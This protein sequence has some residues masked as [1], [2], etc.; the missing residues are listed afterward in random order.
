MVYINVVCGQISFIATVS[1]IQ[2]HMH[3]DLDLTLRERERERER[4]ELKKVS[5]FLT[6]DCSVLVGQS[7]QA[8]GCP[9]WK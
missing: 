3:V 5:I 9:N 1:Y 2:G 8:K 6:R 7:F 4:S